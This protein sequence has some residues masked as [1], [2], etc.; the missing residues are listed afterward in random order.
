MKVKDGFVLRDVGGKT[1][2]L[3]TGAAAISFNGMITLS[4]AGKFLW[5]N[6]EKDCSED[7]LVAALL[8]TY[9]VHED[10]ARKDVHAFVATMREN[11]L[12]DE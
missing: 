9:D 8:K 7:D 11:R 1:V 2:V 6:M 4:G 10:V 5:E 3:A 12:L